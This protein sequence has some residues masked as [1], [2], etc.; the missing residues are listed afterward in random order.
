[1]FLDKDEANMWLCRI[2][3]GLQIFFRFVSQSWY[4][5]L[6][7]TQ[8]RAARHSLW[9]K[10]CE[11]N[12]EKYVRYA[13]TVDLCVAIRLW[14]IDHMPTHTRYVPE[15]VTQ[16]IIILCVMTGHKYFS[17]I[18]S[19]RFLPTAKLLFNFQAQRYRSWH[20]SWKSFIQKPAKESDHLSALEARYLTLND[21]RS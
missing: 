2:C 14:L 1:M 17:M 16:G 11:K 6:F 20:V 10:G 21:C 4:I 8:P 12:A 15:F 9:V 19:V 5:H 13:P 3:L 7:T 18:C